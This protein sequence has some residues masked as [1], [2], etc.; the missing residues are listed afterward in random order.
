M[1]AFIE[2]IESMENDPEKIAEIEK[3]S[4]KPMIEFSKSQDDQISFLLMEIKKNNYN[5][6]LD[7]TTVGVQDE[8]V[9]NT[10]HIRSNNHFKTNPD[11]IVLNSPA[12]FFC[13]TFNSIIIG[14]EFFEKRLFR[15]YVREKNNCSA[16]LNIKRADIVGYQE[17]ENTKFKTFKTSKSLRFAS[18]AGG[19]LPGGLIPLLALDAIISIEDNVKNLKDS[20]GSLFILQFFENKKKV[21]LEI[22]CE[23]WYCPIFRKFLENNWKKELSREYLL[24]IFKNGAEN[25][26]GCYIATMAYGDYNHENVIM[27]RKFRDNILNNYLFGRIFIKIYYKTSPSL[28]VLF[29]DNERINLYIKRTL[30]LF[31]KILS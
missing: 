7:E 4:G 2:S 16:F 22:C 19:A 30:D 23:D 17:I 27:L 14:F 3:A 1:D 26:G 8:Q 11:N 21:T 20:K 12:T 28:V 18:K 25:K 5:F 10:I 13:S 31:V 24:T 9:I 6:V 15:H 29:K